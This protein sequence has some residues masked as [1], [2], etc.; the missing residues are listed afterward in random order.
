MVIQ[1]FTILIKLVVDIKERR[2]S[3]FRKT[4]IASARATH[5]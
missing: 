1:R 5:I 3:G 2:Q 4:K